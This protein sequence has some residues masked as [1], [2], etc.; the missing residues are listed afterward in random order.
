MP[1]GEGVVRSAVRIHRAPALLGTC[2][3][4][5]HL[6]LEVKGLHHTLNFWCICQREWRA[7]L[8]SGLESLPLWGPRM[9]GP[10][11]CCPWCLWLSLQ[12]QV[13][14]GALSGHSLR[15]ALLSF[16]ILLSHWALPLACLHVCTH[17]C[18]HTHARTAELIPRSCI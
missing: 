7:A 4:A 1:S 9:M 18:T 11:S 10:L 2:H 3:G 8:S 6:G 16:S 12:V 13:S 17:A 5:H 14:H 15:C